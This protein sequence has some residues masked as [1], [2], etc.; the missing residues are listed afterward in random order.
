MTTNAVFHPEHGHR[1]PR[2]HTSD[3]TRFLVPLGR[4]LFVAIFVMSGPNHFK[5][6]M[7][8]HASQ[9][10]VP[11]ANLLVPASGVIALLGG[12]SV[13]FGFKARWGA[14]LLVLFLVPVTFM[15]HKFWTISDPAA[16]MMQQVMFMK[17]I[18]MLGAAL[19]IA[20]FGAGPISIDAR[21]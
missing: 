6:Q 11:M 4:L 1:V 9:A 7:I 20:Y 12:L 5:G 8:E 17:N 13:L 10:G 14:W 3:A 15:M 21:R 2:E 18:S 16:A 19:M